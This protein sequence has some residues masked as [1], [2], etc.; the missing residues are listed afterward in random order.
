MHS[1]RWVESLNDLLVPHIFKGINKIYNDIKR[2][3]NATNSRNG[4]GVIKPFQLTLM[5]IKYLPES[6]LEEDYIQLLHYLKNNDKSEKLFSSL[7]TKIYT[8]MAQTELGPKEVVNISIPKNRVFVH[9][10]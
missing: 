2:A 3:S 10:V 5:E 1:W 9:K 6:L 7:L 8:N 4:G